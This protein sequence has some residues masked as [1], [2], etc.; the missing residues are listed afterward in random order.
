MIHFWQSKH[1]GSCIIKTLYFIEFLKTIAS[2][3]DLL[4]RPKILDP[5]HDTHGEVSYKGLRDVV[6][7]DSRWRIANGQLVKTWQHHWLPIKRP[8]MIQSPIIDSMEEAPVDILIEA[9]NRQWNIDLVDGLFAPQEAE[10]I[11]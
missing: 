10:I 7:R 3:I 5:V 2:L 8:L 6:Q 1:G 9:E 11:K 4:W